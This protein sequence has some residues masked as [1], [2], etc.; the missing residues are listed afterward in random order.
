M[1]RPRQTAS[2]GTR[3]LAKKLFKFRAR[4]SVTLLHAER[5][6]VLL[7]SVAQSGRDFTL[8]HDAKAVWHAVRCLQNL[9]DIFLCLGKRQLLAINA[10]DADRVAARVPLSRT[11]EMSRPRSLPT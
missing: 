11:P 5:F 10:P 6:N 3:I 4:P 1:V 7:D 8:C 9:A 2:A